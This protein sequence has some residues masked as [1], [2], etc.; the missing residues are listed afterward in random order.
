M[1]KDLSMITVKAKIKTNVSSKEYPYV[2][3][4]GK[5]HYGQFQER[6]HAVLFRDTINSAIIRDNLLTDIK[7]QNEKV[8]IPTTK[9]Q[10][11][12]SDS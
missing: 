9:Q 2:V 5:K 1:E 12:T 3:C 6:C 7:L 4:I 8:H 11:S 10:R